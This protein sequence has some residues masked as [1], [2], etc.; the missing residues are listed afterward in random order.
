MERVITGKENPIDPR[1]PE[2]ALAEFYRAFNSRD[3][4]LMAQNW[5]DSEE[6]SMDNPLGGIRRGWHDIRGVYQR[7]FEGQA[8]VQ[9]EFHDFTLHQLGEAFLAV[10]RER[11]TLV[12]GGESLDLRIRTSRLFVR[13]G[14][15]WRQF[16]HHGS[17]EDPALLTKYQALVRNPA[18]TP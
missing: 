1:V 6:A 14:A 5:D 18:A 12:A 8:R 11:G 16:H 2:G 4:V 10:G 17:V 13:R 3:L 7:I 15:R 9:V